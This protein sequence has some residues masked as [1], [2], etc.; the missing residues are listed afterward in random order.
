MSNT[1]KQKVLKRW[2]KAVAWQA[3]TS[4]KWYISTPDW[5]GKNLSDGGWRTANAA[6]AS[7]AKSLPASK[8]TQTRS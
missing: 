5:A 4:K 6:W 3:P 7:A 8:T 2:P 1:P